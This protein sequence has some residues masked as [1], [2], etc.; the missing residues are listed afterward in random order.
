[1][2]NDLSTIGRRDASFE[3]L[4][5]RDLVKQ[6]VLETPLDGNHGELHPKGDDFVSEGIPFIMASDISEGQIDYG[7]CKFISAKQA[8]TLRKGFARP[9]DVLL[10]HKGTIGRT[11]IVER[12]Q[13]S[14]LMLTPQVTYYR[15]KDSSRL[16]HRYLRYYFEG[17][18]F[19][20][21]LQLWADSG[22]TRAY[23]GITAQLALPVIL[24]PI[25]KQLKM[26]ALLAAYDKLIET[27][28][29]QIALLANLAEEIYREWFVR[30][31][32]PGC[33]TVSWTKGIPDG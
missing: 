7:A 15:V 25:Q 32:F 30:L 4:T 20:K 33:R 2:K 27:R 14:F 13:Y 5:V 1:M 29:Q 28:K 24:P 17:E 23:L 3:L 26:A 18:F 12:S 10:T 31:R 6:G 19:Q 21:T 22:S 16:N 11:A 9:G 8:G